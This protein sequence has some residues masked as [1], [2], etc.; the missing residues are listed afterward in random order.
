[1]EHHV[2]GVNLRLAIRILSKEI[3]KTECVMDK[4]NVA[5]LIE[6]FM[7][8]SSKTTSTTERER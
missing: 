3:L 1:M 6:M 2:V 5:N 8:V 7:K 4:V